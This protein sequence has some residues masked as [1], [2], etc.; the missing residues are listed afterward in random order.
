M[1][2]F[3]PLSRGIFASCLAAALLW[4]APAG[5]RV[6]KIRRKSPPP[7]RISHAIAMQ[8]E[9]ALAPDFKCLPYADPAAPKGGALHLGEYGAFD[10]LNPY[11]VNA[12]TTARDWPGRSMKA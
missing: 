3:C 12:G 1:R 6:L 8:G 7:G 11:G 5:A 9:P 2:R 10:N 4:L